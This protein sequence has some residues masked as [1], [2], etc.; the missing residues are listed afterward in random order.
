M[1]KMPLYFYFS[2]RKAG[3]ELSPMILHLA[4]PLGLRQFEFRLLQTIA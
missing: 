1:T 2:A 4:S 3:I